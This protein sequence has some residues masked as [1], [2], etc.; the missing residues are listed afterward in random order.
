[1]NRRGTPRW[2]PN[3]PLDGLGDDDFN[4]FMRNVLA[5]RP[6]Y[7]TQMYGWYVTDAVDFV[8]KQERLADDLSRV[9]AHLDVVHDA[10]RL[11]E[12]ARVN[13]STG[14]ERGPVWDPALRDEVADAEGAA[15]QR[16]G[17]TSSHEDDDRR[18]S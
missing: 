14:A 1:V 10:G 16:F 2:H 8:G 4:R 9:L 18:A 17:Y 5:T 6:G 15:L 3:A 11:H 13:V 12:R 7:V